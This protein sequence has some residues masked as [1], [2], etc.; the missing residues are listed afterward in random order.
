MYTYNYKCDK[1]KSPG[2]QLYTS[3]TLDLYNTV[4][5]STAACHVCLRLGL[6]LSWLLGLFDPPLITIIICHTHWHQYILEPPSPPP[7]PATLHPLT[8]SFPSLR[9]NLRR[10]RNYMT[11]KHLC[12]RAIEEIHT[13]SNNLWYG[14]STPEPQTFL[15]WLTRYIPYNMCIIVG[16]HQIISQS[17]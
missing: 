6:R 9:T 5:L 16:S 15:W 1:V 17:R 11:D 2:A 4:K 7:P 10:W 14:R 12:T 13:H 3:Y 8:S